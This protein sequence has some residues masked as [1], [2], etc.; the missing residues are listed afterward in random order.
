MRCSEITPWG[1]VSAKAKELTADEWRE[2]YVA[3]LER[4][5]VEKIQQRFETLYREYGKHP[6][7]LLCWEENPA[8]CHRSYFADWWAA[9]T[10]QVVPE[11][12]GLD[13]QSLMLSLSG[14][15]F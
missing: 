8:D 9:R 15:L 12:I 5:G 13:R 7:A 4:H 3:R 10:S 2:R 14:A 11:A 6:L 1:L